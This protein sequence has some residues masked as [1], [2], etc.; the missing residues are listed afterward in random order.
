METKQLL[1]GF[2]L[3]T[4][5]LSLFAQDEF[6]LVEEGQKAPDFTYE[7]APGKTAKLSDLKGKVVW[8]NFFATWC[9]PCRQELPHLQKEVFDKLKNN[10][11]FELMILGRE[12]SWA[13]INKF[14]TDNKYNLPFYPDTGRKVFSLYAKQNIPRNF[15]IDKEGKVAV[16]S[17]GFNEKEF[18]E[19]VE[20]VEGMLK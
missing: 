12:H 4:F 20:K 8:I 9:G 1:L 14:K 15:I 16:V 10:K 6:T 7:T 19:I 18:G 17:T 13:E 3:F 11:N 2:S 5:S